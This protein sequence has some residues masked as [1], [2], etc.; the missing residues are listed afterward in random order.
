VVPSDCS[1]ACNRRTG[2]GVIERVA[3]VA[4][5]SDDGTFREPKVLE[6]PDDIIDHST[7]VN[8][9]LVTC[10]L[11]SPVLRCHQSRRD[12]LGTLAART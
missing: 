4:T 6:A 8:I 11:R 3:A 10:R 12:T 9:F 5:L 2:A 1:E 7:I